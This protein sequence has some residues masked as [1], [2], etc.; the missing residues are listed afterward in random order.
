MRGV[1]DLSGICRSAMAS[2]V[3]KPSEDRGHGAVLS[4]L[5]PASSPKTGQ[6]LALKL[7]ALIVD[8][9]LKDG[10]H[11]PTEPELVRQLN[12]SRPI[13]REALRILEDE[14]LIEVRR[15]SRSGPRVRIPGPEIVARPAGL[16]LQ[17]SGATLADVDRARG[18]FEPLA[19][20]LLA[21]RGSPKDFDELDAVVADQF[22]AAW[23][24]DEFGAAVAWFHRRLVELCDNSVLA[25]LAG[26]VHD[27]T[28]AHDQPQEHR[29]VTREHFDDLTGSCRR[30]IQLMRDGESRS[31]ERHWRMH[32]ESPHA[33][34]PG[35]LDMVGIR[36][37]PD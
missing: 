16:L 13:V 28:C 15:G 25:L 32:L 24:A 14:R 4:R 34:R 3:P 33:R 18:G 6:L 23:A 19:A 12:V 10:D 35:R 37:V 11:L 5:S 8:G 26:V 20:G 21:T 29:R 2:R 30:L 1:S 27:I 17:L 9:V 22:P 36:D 7:R 31:A